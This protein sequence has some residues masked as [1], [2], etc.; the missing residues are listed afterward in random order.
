MISI[1]YP[2][3]H[4]SRQCHSLTQDFVKLSCTFFFIE[5]VGEE[6]K[7]ENEILVRIIKRELGSRGSYPLCCE[8]SSEPEGVSSDGHFLH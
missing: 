7:G 1:K 6:E 3:L 8:A 5:A 2:Y 4:T